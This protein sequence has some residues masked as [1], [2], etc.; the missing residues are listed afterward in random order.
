MNID[1]VKTTVGYHNYF[2]IS[3]EEA[4]ACVQEKCPAGWRAWASAFRANNPPEGAI[5]VGQ[6]RVH[7]GDPEFPL[8]VIPTPMT[9]NDVAAVL[10]ITP[11]RVRA[12]ARSRGVG[13]QVTRGTWLFSHADLEAMRIR[14]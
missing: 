5:R 2:R 7:Q 1:E 13:Q 3:L 10:G 6:V 12:L 4:V 11:R 8:Y 14:L 9:T